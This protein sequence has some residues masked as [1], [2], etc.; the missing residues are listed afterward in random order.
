MMGHREKL[1]GGLEFD[2]LTGWRRFY[3]FKAGE[4]KYAKNKLTRRVRREVK[5]K[6]SDF[7]WQ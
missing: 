2:A 6:L 5:A 7:E 3:K 1:K 4:R